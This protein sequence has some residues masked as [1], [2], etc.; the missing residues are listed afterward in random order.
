VQTRARGDRRAVKRI[1]LNLLSNAVKFTP[2][3]GRIM[4]ST[5]KARGR[6]YVSVHDTGIGISAQDLSRLGNPF[7]QA[8]TD[9][10][11]AKGGTGLGLALVKALVEKHGGKLVMASEVGKGTTVVVDFPLAAR[12]RAQA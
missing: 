5:W 9:A 3:D 7:E 4:V 10:I 8:E 11:H 1:L 12:A 6:A 2:P